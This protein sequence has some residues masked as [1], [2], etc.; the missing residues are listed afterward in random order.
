[1]TERYVK[2]TLIL[3]L[4]NIVS[5]I[6]YKDNLNNFFCFRRSSSGMGI[7]YILHQLYPNTTAGYRPVMFIWWGVGYALFGYNH[8]AFRWFIILLHSV[9][10]II[11]YCIVYHLS[12][13]RLAGVT[14]GLFYLCMPIHSDAVNWLSAASNQVTCA[15]FYLTTIFIYLA[16][17]N[18]DLKKTKYKKSTEILCTSTM[19]LAMSTN[20]VA[21]TIIFVLFGINLIIN[22]DKRLRPTYIL[23]LTL[24]RIKYYLIAWLI[25]VIWRAFAVH[26]I[27][28]YGAS[29]HLRVGD[30]LFQTS[31]SIVRMLLLP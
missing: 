4:V 15:F 5:I 12:R 23:K 24:S 16:K 8:F 27:G 26:G 14:S 3:L 2:N 7:K 10:T 17:I 1:M 21:L 20:E 11:V 25:F 28:G 30:F 31:E 19:I 18:H 9:N 13:V 29:T 22:F 6:I